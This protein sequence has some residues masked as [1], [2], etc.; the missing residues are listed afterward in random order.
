MTQTSSATAAARTMPP[1]RSYRVVLK[2][3]DGEEHAIEIAHLAD[4]PR[5]TTM[6]G[7][8]LDIAGDAAKALAARSLSLEAFGN[9]SA[10]LDALD[11][12]AD[13]FEVVGIHKVGPAQRFTVD[14]SYSD[15]SG[16]WTDTVEGVDVED[17]EFQ[18]RWQ[19][20]LNANELPSERQAFLESLD[21]HTIHACDPTPVT[22]EEFATEVVAL[23]RAH[24]SGASLADHLASLET[25][26][27]HL[28]YRLD[29]A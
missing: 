29:H 8:A 3:A 19:M 4:N 6:L 13:R 2:D 15:V 28:G 10:Y 1:A 5:D 9:D 25:M 27:G 14:A 20:S 24:R 16:P 18:A 7:N 11:R 17:A 23:L 26:V 22:Q 21:G 12:L